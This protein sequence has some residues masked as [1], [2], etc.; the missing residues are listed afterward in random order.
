MTVWA[1]IPVKPLNRAKSRLSKVL[2]HEQRFELAQMMLKQVLATV[3]R[4]PQI[5]GTLVISRDTMAIGM[6]RDFGVKTIQESSYSDL[7]PALE[8]ATGVLRAW[9]ADALLI[10]PADLPFITSV[11][12][13]AL[14]E[15]GQE[16]DSVVI[17]TDHQQNGTN[18]LLVRP[19]GLLHYAFG[20]GSFARHQQLAQEA[21]AKL[22][23]YAAD[24]VKLDVDEPVDLDLYNQW[25]A[26]GH[27][28]HLKAFYP[29]TNDFI[30]PN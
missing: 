8:R 7:N 30:S 5:T 13:A 6:A 21:G 25:V 22:A 19:P 11:D 14:I 4:T 28:E 9:R 15:L 2:S 26:A 16:E 3:T 1:V 27:Y 10:L 23:I 24:T 17:A 18:A 20:Q 12:I 29:V